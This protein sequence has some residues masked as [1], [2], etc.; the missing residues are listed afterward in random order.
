MVSSLV[1]RALSVCSGRL[2]VCVCIVCRSPGSLAFQLQTKN[3][4]VKI[5]IISGNY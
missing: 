2:Y 3:I 4:Y 1:M 5:A